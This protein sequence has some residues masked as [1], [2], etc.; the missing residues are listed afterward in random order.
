MGQPG[1][2]STREKAGGLGGQGLPGYCGQGGSPHRL[3]FRARPPTAHH[4][5]GDTCRSPVLEDATQ[6]LKSPP[7]PTSRSWPRRGLR[8]P[9]LVA[10]CWGRRRP[11]LRA[12]G[13]DPH[14]SRGAARVEV[15]PTW[16]WPSPRAGLCSCWMMESSK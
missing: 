4:H 1:R 13:G 11:T 16:Y 10:T 9:R 7:H 6:P 15:A 2:Q 12:L 5:P 3:L 14:R 8:S